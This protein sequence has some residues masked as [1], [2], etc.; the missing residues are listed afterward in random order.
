MMLPRMFRR[1]MSIAQLE[2]LA[3]RL[4]VADAPPAL[5]SLRHICDSEPSA[6]S[7]IA[8]MLH[9]SLWQDKQTDQLWIH[10]RG[11]VAGL[12]VWYGPG[13]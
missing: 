11:G 6:D 7:F 5:A 4:P 8:D 9:W 3:Q 12:D 13:T 10:C 2:R 1:K